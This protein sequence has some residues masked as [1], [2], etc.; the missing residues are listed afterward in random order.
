MKSIYEVNNLIAYNKEDLILRDYFKSIIEQKITKILK[1]QNSAWQF[2]EFEA[3]CL[4]TKDKISSNYTNEDYFEVISDKNLALKPET[5]ASSFEVAYDMLK[6]NEIRAPFCVWQ[7]SKS[8]RQEADQ[9]FKHIRFKEFYHLEFQCIFAKDSF[10]NYQE[11]TIDDI[12]QMFQSILKLPTRIVLSDRLPY[13][14]LKTID[15]EVQ[16]CDKWMEVCSVSLRKDF[17]YKLTEKN[18]TKEF[19][20]LEIATSID[21]LIYNFNEVE[22][23]YNLKIEKNI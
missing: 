14:S 16:N 20:V 15:I 13:Y 22:K 5:T 18:K 23:F 7:C 8:F 6:H 3:P 10:N 9:S 21:R 17:E 12:A 11:T 4:I 2:V 19:L 1:K